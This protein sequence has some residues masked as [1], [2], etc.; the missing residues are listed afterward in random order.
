MDDLL[1]SSQ[2]TEMQ[3]VNKQHRSIMINFGDIR[4]VLGMLVAKKYKET[5]KIVVYNM[6]LLFLQCFCH[7]ETNWFKYQCC[8]DRKSCFSCLTWIQTIRNHQWI[9]K[10]FL[11]CLGSIELRVQIR[12]CKNL[13]NFKFSN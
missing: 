7:L 1:S 11:C 2:Q 9:V 10:S 5:S 12:I 6:N 4:E 13:I 8:T 3:Q